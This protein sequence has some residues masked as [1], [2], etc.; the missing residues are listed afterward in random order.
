MKIANIDRESLHIFWTTWRIS[1]K[2]S[3]KIWLMIILKVTKNQGFT[4]ALEDTSSE[5]SKGG[6]K[7]THPVFLGL[8][9]KYIERWKNYEAPWGSK[10]NLENMVRN[11]GL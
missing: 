3:G 11:L 8:S 6:V 10:M 5:K 2:F 4:I 7:L 9:L 1:M